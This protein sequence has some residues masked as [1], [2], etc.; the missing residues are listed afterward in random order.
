MKDGQAG[1]QHTAIDSDTGEA[2]MPLLENTLV[3][4][5][6]TLVI[7]SLYGNK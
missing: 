3:Y 7:L 6:P 1:R 2:V 4:K 5:R